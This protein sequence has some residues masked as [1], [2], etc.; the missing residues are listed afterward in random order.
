MRLRR[1]CARDV[2]GA[3]N[4][5]RL[6]ASHTCARPC[7]IPQVAVRKRDARALTNMANTAHSATTEPTRTELVVLGFSK[8]HC[9]RLRKPMIVRAGKF[10]PSNFEGRNPRARNQ[11]RAPTTRQNHQ[12]AGR[13]AM[14][15]ARSASRRESARLGYGKSPATK[16]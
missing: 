10:R 4:M 5:I 2:Y 11:Y 7:R 15:I 9:G 6:A 8:S 13:N 12:F 3:K 14:K 16:W 1:R